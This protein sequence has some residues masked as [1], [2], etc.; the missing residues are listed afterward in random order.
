MAVIKSA[1]IGLGSQSLD[2]LTYRSV[3]GRTIASRRV[4]EN[5]SRTEKQLQ[6]RSAFSEVCSL[7]KVLKPLI[8][9]GFDKTEKGSRRNNFTQSNREYMSYLKSRV[10]PPTGPMPPITTLCR[11][12][13]D[14]NFT[15]RVM[16]SKGTNSVNIENDSFEWDSN[17]SP[18]ATLTLSRA[19]EAKD[20]VLIVAC[21][22]Y[23]IGNNY[24]GA[25]KKFETVLGLPAINALPEPT[26][27]EVNK[28]T[29]PGLDGLM[30]LPSKATNIEIAIA[31]I[32]DGVDGRTDS[33]FTLM[34]NQ[35]YVFE[36]SG[37]TVIESNTVMQILAPE[38]EEFAGA[39]F[40][41]AIGSVLTLNGFRYVVKGFSEE[42]EVPNGLL[43]DAPVGMA[44]GQPYEG[45]A[46]GEA[47]PLVK[48]DEVIAYISGL[49]NPLLAI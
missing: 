39:L 49:F 12:L 9:I 11:S 1:A 10:T 42:N 35:P 18:Y 36:T 33:Y 17:L 48:G 5:K 44:Y 38:A 29:L 30:N 24:Y 13:R 32:V 25:V 8:E 37:Q 14:T 47:V 20:T 19:F 7:A 6:H 26:Q 23:R 31:A 41:K 15:G 27:F 22:S 3:R 43:F 21:Y 28:E 4:T 46:V 16:A 40:E 45:E 2:V 34:P